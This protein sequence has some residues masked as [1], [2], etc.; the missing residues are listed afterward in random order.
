M[1]NRTEFAAK[2]AYE[3][4]RKDEADNKDILHP[5]WEEAAESEKE[6]WRQ[7]ANAAV[8]A[9]PAPFFL[10][11]AIKAPPYGLAGHAVHWHLFFGSSDEE[12]ERAGRD[13]VERMKSMRDG[14]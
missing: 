5:K 13:F 10:D 4:H 1:I 14:V 8:G 3:A 11:I 2:A 7:I 9:F 12:I 6:K